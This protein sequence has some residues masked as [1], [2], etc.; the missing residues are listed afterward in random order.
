M[1]TQ[2]MTQAQQFVN[3]Q[4]ATM[5]RPSSFEVRMFQQ[6]AI[7]ESLLARFAGLFAGR[8]QDAAPM[9]AAALTSKFGK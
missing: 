6:S 5:V 4:V 2:T 3:E 9:V 7:V 8:T 1:K